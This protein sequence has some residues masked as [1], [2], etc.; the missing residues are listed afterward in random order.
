MA[1]NAA[2]TGNENKTAKGVIPSADDKITSPEQ[3]NDY[4]KVTN[5][6]VWVVFAVVILIMI[7]FVA[8]SCAGTIEPLTNAKIVTESITPISFLL[9]K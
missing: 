3:L 5:P 9:Q 7:A 4:L 6:R 8:W 1:E 2:N